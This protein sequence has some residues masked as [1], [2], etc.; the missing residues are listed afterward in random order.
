MTLVGVEGC[1]GRSKN[2]I[3]ARVARMIIYENYCSL[4]V[5]TKCISKQLW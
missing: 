4:Y 1:A 2:V 5:E 3:F